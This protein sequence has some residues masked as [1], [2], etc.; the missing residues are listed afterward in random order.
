MKNKLMLLIVFVLVSCMSAFADTDTSINTDDPD[1]LL[2]TVDELLFPREGFSRDFTEEQGYLNEV[3]P[4]RI[5]HQFYVHDGRA[6]DV[7]TAVFSADRTVQ[8]S[9]LRLDFPDSRADN[10]HTSITVQRTEN[11]P[12]GSGDCW[13]RYSNKM[14]KSEG[15]ETAVVFIP[16]D[17]V[18][19]VSPVD[20]KPAA[21]AVADLSALDPDEEI[22][23]DFIRLDG[24]VYV[25]ADEVFLFTYEDGIPGKVTFDAGTRMLENG[26][27]VCCEFDDFTMQLQY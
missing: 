27:R 19:A 1:E 22:K 10:F 12:E 6:G 20:G 15:Y 2:L 14:V 7:L 17:A 9:N 23:F 18:Y 16:G 8:T 13:I 21:A 5:I 4:G 26:N 11:L 24:T 25:Y 3:L